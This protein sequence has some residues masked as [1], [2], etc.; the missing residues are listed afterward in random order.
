MATDRLPPNEEREAW[1]KRNVIRL[2]DAL[3]QPD[4]RKR[5]LEL[6]DGDQ[7]HRADDEQKP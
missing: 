5:I 6:L 4:A 7:P 3:A 1:I 2:R